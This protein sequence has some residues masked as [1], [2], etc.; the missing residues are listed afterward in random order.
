MQPPPETKSDALCL[1]GASLQER[2]PQ[3]QASQHRH[4]L[5]ADEFA[6]D[7]MPGI[8]ARFANVDRHCLVPQGQAERESSQTSAD[9]GD[10]FWHAEVTPPSYFHKING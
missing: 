4:S 1:P 3:T 7:P 2:I 5:A 6:A 9:N 10:F 8:C